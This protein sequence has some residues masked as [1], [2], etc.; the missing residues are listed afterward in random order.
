MSRLMAVAE[1]VAADPHRYRLARAGVLNVW[2]YDEQIFELADGRML[3]RGANGAGKSKTLEMLLPFV[4]DGDKRRLNAS[5]GQ[6]HTSL[7]WLMLESGSFGAPSRIGYVWVE[8][9][10]TDDAGQREVITCGIGIRA[11]ASAKSATAWHFT[12]P[13]AVGDGLELADDSGPLPPERCRE[14]VEPDGMYFDQHA[15]QA[16]KEHV[17]RT[18]FGLDADR[19][20][21]LLRMLYWLRRPQVGEDIDPR[22]LAETLSVALPQLDEDLLRSAGESLDQLADFGDQIESLARATEAVQSFAGTYRQYAATAV[23][24]RARAVLDAIAAQRK[25]HGALQEREAELAEAQAQLTAAERAHADAEERLRAANTRKAQLEAS[26]EARSQQVLWEKERR[27]GDLTKSAARAVEG[28]R[29]ADAEATRLHEDAVA[30]ADHLGSDLG[31]VIR[32]AERFAKALVDQRVGVTLAVPRLGD[33]PHEVSDAE[34]LWSTVDE[35]ASGVAECRPAIGTAR[36]AVRAVGEAL[37][38]AE[39]VD[40]ELAKA[41][42]RVVDAEQAVDDSAEALRVAE[43]RVA[44][45]ESAFADAL[46]AWRADDRAIAL[47]LPDE[48][49]AA[50]LHELP[51][52]ARTAAQPRLTELR[53]QHV[54]ALGER[55]TVEGRLHELREQRV[56]IAAE[57]D[58]APAPPPLPRT[59]RDPETGDPLWRLIDFAGGLDAGQGAG[60]EA[61]LESS[62]LLDAWVRSDGAV[63]DAQT[64]DVVLASGPAEAGPTLADVLVPAPAED[65]PVAAGTVRLLLR[66]IRLA[67]AEQDGEPGVRVAYDGTWRLGPLEGRASKPVA[68]YVGA[69]ARAA[70][71]A[72]RLAEVDEQIGDTEAALAEVRQVL[73]DVASRIG[74]LEAW[75][76]AVPPTA[77]LLHAWSQAQAEQTVHERNQTALDERLQQAKVKRTEANAAAQRLTDL[78]ELHGLPTDRAGLDARDAGLAELDR[79]AEGHVERCGRLRSP[80]DK[81]ARDR[82]RANAKRSQADQATAAAEEAEQIAVEARTEYEELRAT[83][84]AAVDELERRLREIRGQQKRAEADRKAAEESRRQWSSEHG[85]YGEQVAEARRAVAHHAPV[86][87]AAL[88]MFGAL[89]TIEGL[90]QT[91]LDRPPDGGEVAA[92][93]AAEAYAEGDAVTQPVQRLARGLTG[94]QPEQPVQSTTVLGRWNDLLASEAGAVDPRWFEQ[95]HVVVVVGRDQAGEH[96]IGVLAHRMAA[97]LASDRGL[98]TEREGRI[99]TEHLMGGDA[100]RK[101]RQEAEE[102]VAAM[103]RLLSNVSTSQGITVRLDWRLKDDV[104]PEV[105]EAAELLTKPMGALLP[106]ERQR[107]K[108]ALHR[109][110]ES[111]R[112]EHPE[113]DYTEHLHAALDYRIW[114]EFRIRI[115]RPEAPD[116][117]KVLTRRTPLSQGEQKVVCYLP[118]FAAASAHFTSVAGAAADAPRFILLDDAFPKID[119]KTHPK[120]FGLL[121]DFDLDFVVTSERLWGD[122]ETVPKLAIYEALRSPTERGIAQYKHLWDGRRLYAV[123]MS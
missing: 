109:L 56:A 78:A 120:L 35:H 16:Y 36:A 95:Q 15:S 68:Q 66:R 64:H 97:K 122:Y 28:A 46:A 51:G 14:A 47:E 21:E 121:V 43:E 91:V 89:H 3:L 26:P 50:L 117:W 88:H 73:A 108:D 107:L 105:R 20:D 104:V 119:V 110:I 85:A 58:P 99:F 61:A 81:W 71:R 32:H 41:E 40:R 24:E 93:T 82:E 92:L 63:L 8:F 1:E 44:A 17:G 94:R 98:F 112:D 4:L 25:L 114:S 79:Q 5:G 75:L 30:D 45:A 118:L 84:G 90:L 2:Q 65:S 102:L 74:A 29:G 12:S 115:K 111:S 13:Y 55:R 10:R 83:F 18:L 100:L 76:T 116:D 11:S 86:Q 38:E 87:A 27:A 52:R 67:D 53:E 60:L 70:E 96:P 54:A 33:P 106:D 72:R 69:G 59:P 7:L 101:R 6:H 34:R 80:L 103:N 31:A 22:S 19:Y 9:A 48:L 57:R 37:A 49:D 23:A 62:G 42:D 123:G 113:L 39:R 77:D